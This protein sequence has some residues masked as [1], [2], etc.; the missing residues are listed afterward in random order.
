MTNRYFLGPNMFSGIVSFVTYKGDL[1]GYPLD[2][3]LLKQEYDGLQIPR[4]FYAPRY[5]TQNQQLTRMPDARTLL[6]WNP[7]V[8]VSREGQI[9]FF[10]SDQD[11]RYLIEVHG[12]SANGQAGTQR[13]WFEVKGLVK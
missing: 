3:R 11:G 10:T 8:T 12:L 13:A 7:S 1:S 2:E 4:E 9:D 5:E 6:Y